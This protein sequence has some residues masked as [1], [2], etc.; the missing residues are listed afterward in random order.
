MIEYFTLLFAIPIGIVLAKLT[1]H[2]KEIYKK[3]QYFPAILIFL[4]ILA[5]GTYTFDKQLSLTLTF[6]LITTFVWNK[7]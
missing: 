1:T 5:L 4:A 6:I 7:T 2:E 3:K